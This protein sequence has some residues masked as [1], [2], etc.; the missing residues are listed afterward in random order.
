MTSLEKII[1]EIRES[2]ETAER[3]S[4]SRDVC[5]R[6]VWL[7]GDIVASGGSRQDAAAASAHLANCLRLGRAVRARD[8]SLAGVV[9][10]TE[11]LMTRI[12][13]TGDLTADAVG[14]AI[15]VVV[16]DVTLCISHQQ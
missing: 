14:A 1:R 5:A 2:E 16:L 4:T 3:T 12:E 15:E 6:L 7:L 11:Q 13:A 9:A 8:P 10:S